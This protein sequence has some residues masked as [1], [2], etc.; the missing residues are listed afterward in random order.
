[1]GLDDLGTCSFL[2]DI[3]SMAHETKYSRLFRS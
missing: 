2:A 3:A 1:A